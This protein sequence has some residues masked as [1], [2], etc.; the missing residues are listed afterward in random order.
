MTEHSWMNQDVTLN[1]LA[2]VVQLVNAVQ[3]DTFLKVKEDLMTYLRTA[4]RCPTLNIH[5]VVAP[6][7]QNTKPY[8]AKE[9]FDYLVTKYP[10]LE[11]LQQ[12]LSLEVED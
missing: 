2:V 3:Q 8:T 7:Q 5:G 10:N 1:G 4:L 6:P 9:R 12:K 11:L